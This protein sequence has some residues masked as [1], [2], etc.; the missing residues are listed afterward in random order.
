MQRRSKAANSLPNTQNHPK[1]AAGTIFGM[2]LYP[3]M[4]ESTYIT[5]L[6]SFFLISASFAK[7]ENVGM[8]KS[9]FV[10]LLLCEAIAAAHRYIYVL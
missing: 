7:K 5:V 3:Y 2:Y 9:H 1:K 6:L 4:D 10:T 8:S